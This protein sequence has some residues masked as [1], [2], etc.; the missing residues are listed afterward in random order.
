MEVAC[1][2][3]AVN[4]PSYLFCMEVRNWLMFS[5]NVEN[6]NRAGVASTMTVKEF[7]DAKRLE[8][9]RYAITVEE[10]KTAGTYGGAIIHLSSGLYKNM[11]NYVEH[12]RP[13]FEPKGQFMFT[14]TLGLQFQSEQIHHCLKS[15]AKNTGALKEETLKAFSSTML[16]K[17][18]VTSTR[19]LTSPEKNKIAR[20]TADQSYS[21][22]DKLKRTAEA[23]RVA[24]EII[25]GTEMLWK[26]ITAKRHSVSTCLFKWF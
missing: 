15:F 1:A 9:E 23:H 13:R 17:F 21:M 25:E 8:D 14:S 11:C 3:S 22:F 18:I 19:G 2:C 7:N 24:G 12:I 26:A 10:H 6:F 5:I 4:K 16:R 20:S